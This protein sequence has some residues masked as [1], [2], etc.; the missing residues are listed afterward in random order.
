M[1][2]VCGFFMDSPWLGATGSALAAVLV[3]VGCYV[4]LRNMAG[5]PVA[6]DS[7]A[8]S[9]AMITRL[10]RLHALLPSLMFIQEIDSALRDLQASN[11]AHQDLRA[12][13]LADR[14]D[15]G[16][17]EFGSAGQ[18]LVNPPCCLCVRAIQQECPA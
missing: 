17:P 8:F 12:Q 13:M 10:G 6:A 1:N 14:D 11:D 16:V 3:A 15:H 2:S 9:G 4:V 7:T 18:A 5:L